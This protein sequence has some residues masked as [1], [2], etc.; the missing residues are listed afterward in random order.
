MFTCYLDDSDNNEG[1]TMGIAGYVARRDKWIEFEQA[2][3]PYLDDWGVNVLRGKDFHN[4]HG[5]FKDWDG[6]KKSDFV[7]G[8]YEI[9]TQY[10]YFGIAALVSKAAAS[11]LREKHAQLNNLSPLGIAFAHCAGSIITKEMPADTL[12]GQ[13]SFIVESGNR[14]NG[15]LVRYFHWLQSQIPLFKQAF[16]SISF[17]DKHDCRGVQLA[18]FLAFHARRASDKWAA[19]GW[20]PELPDDPAMSKMLSHMHHRFER[21]F[22][23][24]LETKKEMLW[25]FSL[26]KE[27]HPNEAFA[28]LP[29]EG[30]R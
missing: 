19:N 18:D 20:P 16:G 5:C 22:K 28:F 13:I 4:G 3:A 12:P 6:H 23:D 26:Y 2:V 17:V 21:I 7:D 8:L 9:S 11:S 30:L 27:L 15:N 14:N 29:T 10:I 24:R 25:P 1:P